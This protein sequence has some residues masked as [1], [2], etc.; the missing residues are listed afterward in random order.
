MAT[1]RFPKRRK[2]GGGRDTR[3]CSAMARGA[4]CFLLP[5]FC[6]LFPFFASKR[7]EGEKN[8][9]ADMG[10]V[11]QKAFK[12]GS[13][14]AGWPV[15]LFACFCPL[16]SCPHCPSPG[17]WTPSPAMAEQH[18]TFPHR[19]LDSLRLG[20]R[21]PLD[22]HWPIGLSARGAADTVRYLESILGLQRQKCSGY[23]KCLPYREQTYCQSSQVLSKYP[24]KPIF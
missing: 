18:L 15:P 8:N 10:W 9:Q 17:P 11:R 13:G 2:R 5:R 16:T 4:F 19:K 20:R 21:R 1:L 7:V 14:L 24:S 22:R 3:Y 12:S 23:D 6:F